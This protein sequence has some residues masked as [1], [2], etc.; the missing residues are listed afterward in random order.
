[1]SFNIAP[2]SSSSFQNE[3]INEII[4]A[5]NSLSLS[6][7]PDSDFLS[8]AQRLVFSGTFLPT[9]STTIQWLPSDN[10]LTNWQLGGGATTTAPLITLSS[11]SLSAV[12]LSATTASLGQTTCT[13]LS[14]SGGTASF[15]SASVNGSPVITE[16]NMPT[17][18]PPLTT[19]FGIFNVSAPFSGTIGIMQSGTVFT[20]DINISITTAFSNPTTIIPSST[21]T[22]N[23][24][25]LFNRLRAG[26]MQTNITTLDQWIAGSNG[27]VDVRA[28]VSMDNNGMRIQG[29]TGQLNV[30]DSFNV[31]IT[32]A[33]DNFG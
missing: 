14:Q 15:T 23:I 20:M 6:G 5:L 25:Q 2:Q 31:M 11:N 10:T 3:V 21:T 1:M 19:G 32:W 30:N 9:N 8:M 17:I 24:N 13:S 27:N 18:P 4:E 22:A 26:G 29:V 33:C 7:I 16:A 12:N 28:L